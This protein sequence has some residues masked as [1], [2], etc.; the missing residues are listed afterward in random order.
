MKRP[1]R[2]ALVDVNNFFCSCERV[3]Q[4]RYEGVPI[5]VLSNNDGCVVARSAEAKALG[6]PMCAPWHELK[7]VARKHHVVAFSSNYTLYGDLSA[8]CMRV[9][10]QWVPPED[11]EVVRQLILQH[12]KMVHISQRRDLEDPTVIAE[13][14]GT[15]PDLELLKMLYILTYCDTRAVGPGAWSDWK[16]MLLSDLYRKTVLFLQGQNPIPPMDAAARERLLHAGPF[17]GAFVDY[18]ERQ[19]EA[20]CEL[21][22][23]RCRLIRSSTLDIDPALKAQ[24]RILAILRTVA[25]SDYLNAPGGRA[26]Y[27]DGAFAAEGLKLHFLDDYVGPSWSLLHRLA[28]ETV[29]AVR[30]E[31]LAQ[32]PT[33]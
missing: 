28:S 33:I 26:L 3:F 21:L 29:Q 20:A 17:L 7:D 4:P 23:L 31:I 12:L 24:D 25:A 19:L 27:Q 18:A 22:G 32:T 15:V 13:M 10:G 11:Q 30:T 8:R 5:V 14:A 2:I 6:I 1:R 16:G 9:I